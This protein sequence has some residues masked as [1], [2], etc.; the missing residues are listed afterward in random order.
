LKCRKTLA[1]PKFGRCKNRYT[2][3]ESLDFHDFSV[4]KGVIQGRL[5][6]EAAL[7]IEQ[8]ATTWSDQIALTVDPVTLLRCVPGFYRQC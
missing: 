6:M 7:L 3:A 5:D 1:P 2:I 4:K 8:G